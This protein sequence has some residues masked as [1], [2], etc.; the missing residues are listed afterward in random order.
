MQCDGVNS[1]FEE[2]GA[3]KLANK[4]RVRE[5]GGAEEE[6]EE[7]VGEDGDAAQEC[8]DEEED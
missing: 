2:E 3:C 1:G 6:E 5:D 8:V 4:G 7:T